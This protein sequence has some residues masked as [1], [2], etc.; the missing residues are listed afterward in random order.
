MTQ[1]SRPVAE[2][3]SDLPTLMNKLKSPMILAHRLDIYY[4]IYLLSM[5]LLST[6]PANAEAQAYKQKAVTFMRYVLDVAESADESRLIEL[7]EDRQKKSVLNPEYIPGK[8]PLV[9]FWSPHQR[10]HSLSQFHLKQVVQN[11]LAFEKKKAVG[12]IASGKSKDTK[13]QTQMLTREERDEYR[14]IIHNGKFYKREQDDTFSEMNT[15]NHISKNK[16]GYAG[17]VINIH[18]EISLFNHN[19]AAGGGE[20]LFQIY[21]SSMNKGGLVFTA[22]EAEI[23]GS[24]LLALTSFSGHYQPPAI[25]F[26]EVLKY[27]QSQQ[28]KLDFS[29][30]QMQEIPGLVKRSKGKLPGGTENRFEYAAQKYLEH[31]DKQATA[32]GKRRQSEG[33]INHISLAKRI[34]LQHMWSVQEALEKLRKEKNKGLKLI[35][36]KLT[37]NKA[38]VEIDQLLNDLNGLKTAFPAIDTPSAYHEMQKYFDRY[39]AIY[40]HAHNAPSLFVKAKSKL[41]AWSDINYEQLFNFGFE[42]EN[43]EKDITFFIRTIHIRLA[44]DAP[45]P[46]IPLDLPALRNALSEMEQLKNQVAKEKTAVTFNTVTETKAKIPGWQAKLQTLRTTI[47]IPEPDSPRLLRKRSSSRTSSFSMPSITEENKIDAEVKKENSFSK[48]EMGQAPLTSSSSTSFSSL[49]SISEADPTL[50]GNNKKSEEKAQTVTSPSSIA[51]RKTH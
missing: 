51:R 23:A 25:N 27:F 4:E 31:F 3:K 40:D 26:H 24:N 34:L 44:P 19:A 38:L 6:A 18:G 46:A 30:W 43:I 9:S 14:V 1:S 11:S 33:L 22:G 13:L 41:P 12:V 42:F 50:F 39:K 47:N 16:A 37:N 17:F 49:G 28:V 8:K 45:V 32:Q 20:R 15:T 48:K 35:V 2:S 36:N 7:M 5:Q 29:V 21:H 10:S